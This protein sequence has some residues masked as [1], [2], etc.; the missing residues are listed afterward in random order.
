MAVFFFSSSTIQS[1]QFNSGD[2]I[3]YSAG[4]ADKYG[5]GQYTGNRSR[6]YTSGVAAN[7]SVGWGIATSTYG[8]FNDLLTANAGLVGTVG[9][10]F[11]Q[12]LSR[13]AAP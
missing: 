2:A 5:F 9:T 7:A 11:W 3:G 1:S 12:P 6:V 4:G 13:S 8:V 10:S